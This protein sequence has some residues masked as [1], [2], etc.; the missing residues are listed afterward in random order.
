MPVIE[1]PPT[2]KQRSPQA[3]KER[4]VYRP[5]LDALRFI[6]FFAVFLHHSFA[7]NEAAATNNLRSS[8]LLH[9][10]QACGFGLS[11]FFFLSAF[12]ITSLLQMEKDRSGTIVISSFYIRRVLRIWPLYFFIIFSMYGLG[13]VY[14][15]ARFSFV[16]LL[17]LSL[18][19]GNWY[20]LFVGPGSPTISSLWSIS[21]EE[22]FYLAWP[23][24]FRRLTFKGFR[25]F[26]AAL[27]VASLVIVAI[28]ARHGIPALSLWYNSFAEMVFFGA[29]ALLATFIG[30]RTYYKSLPIALLSVCCGAVLWYYAAGLS[31]SSS[32]MTVMPAGAV[33]GY[34]LDALGC[35]AILWGFLC[36]PLWTLPAPL[37]YLGRISY[38][39]YV[40]HRI[41]I[42]ALNSL[43]GH[44]AT[45][46]APIKVM[47]KILAFGVTVLLA[48]ISYKF[49]EKPFLRLKSR[50]EVVR[51]SR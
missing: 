34:L 30:M 49:F 38:G 31:H 1:G 12:L 3:V 26:S 29:G 50:F 44:G 40:F 16:Q 15:P 18:L 20:S 9:L 11:L 5:E 4:S 10:Q 7:I 25:A 35:G 23:W 36:L 6:A 8:I 21:V 17:A 46:S 32:L 42:T 39:L 51:T 28:L 41:A 24:L 43:L 27:S 13:Y 14:P 22:Q 45:A 19:I 48:S 47:S 33:A 2:A 37:I